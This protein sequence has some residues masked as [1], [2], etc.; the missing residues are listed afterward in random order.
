[1]AAE[2]NAPAFDTSSFCCMRAA[3]CSISSSA[4]RANAFGKLSCDKIRLLAGDY[5]LQVTEL[6][7]QLDNVQRHPVRLKAGRQSQFR[8][9]FGSPCH[10]EIDEFRSPFKCEMRLQL[11]LLIFEERSIINEPWLACEHP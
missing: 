10:L 5:H 8:V 1:M 9:A 11:Q 6:H 2:M 4:K 7:I 3:G